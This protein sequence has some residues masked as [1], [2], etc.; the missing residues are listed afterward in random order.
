MNNDWRLPPGSQKVV[1]INP[2]KNM[3]TPHEGS[4]WTCALDV[5]KEL[6]ID[7]EAGRIQPPDLIYIAM[8]TRNPKDKALVAYPSYCWYPGGMAGLAISGLLAK[9]Q[10]K[11]CMFGE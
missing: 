9:H 5:L 2:K 3:I 7:I 4:H 6:I 1:L 11:V 10:H 8:Q